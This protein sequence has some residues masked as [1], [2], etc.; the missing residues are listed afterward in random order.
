[1]AKTPWAPRSPAWTPAGRLPYAL[2]CLRCAPPLLEGGLIRDHYHL[3]LCRRHSRLAT[4]ARQG[5]MHRNI[6]LQEHRA[7]S[8]ASDQR[9]RSEH[10]MLTLAFGTVGLRPHVSHVAPPGRLTRTSTSAS[11]CAGPGTM[12]YDYVLCAYALY[13]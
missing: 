7:Q 3:L 12:T 9:E 6:G 4:V 11:I 8:S 13:A 5:S 2:P 10:P 1:V